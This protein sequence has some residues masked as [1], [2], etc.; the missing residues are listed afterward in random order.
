MKK[1]IAVIVGVVIVGGGSFYGGIKYDQSKN[2]PV[3][4]GAGSGNFVGGRGARGA[5]Q[6]SAGGFT[7]GE[8]ASRDDKSLTIKLRDGGSKIVF[9]SG[10]TSVMKSAAGDV[11]DVSIGNQVIVMGSANSDGSLTAQSI[12]IRPDTPQQTSQQN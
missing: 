12:Q 7:A 4:R 6:G 5:G 9:F 2:P 11:A 3:V 1:I 10:S 8:V